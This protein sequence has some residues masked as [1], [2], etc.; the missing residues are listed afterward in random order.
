MAKT[1]NQLLAEALAEVKDSAIGN[2][3]HSKNIKAPRQDL[4]VKQ[5]KKRVKYH[6]H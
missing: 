2:I 4:L 5:R 6:I 1:E 3:V